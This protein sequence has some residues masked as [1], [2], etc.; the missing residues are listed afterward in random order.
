MSEDP[1][2]NHKREEEEGAHE[3]EGDQEKPGQG[4]PGPE[5]VVVRQ[6]NF[7]LQVIHDVALRAHSL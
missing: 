1:L 5:L 2:V 6:R 7:A 3:A 4:D